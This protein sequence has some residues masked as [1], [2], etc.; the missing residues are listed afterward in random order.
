MAGARQKRRHV[1]KD[2]DIE[3]DTLEDFLKTSN[4]AA[5]ARIPGILVLVGLR[6]ESGLP[7]DDQEHRVSEF[8]EYHLELPG[9][10]RARGVDEL[11]FQAGLALRAQARRQE[12][13]TIACFPY[14]QLGDADK[15]KDRSSV[16]NFPAF[17][18]RA[19]KH[20]E[21]NSTSLIGA[22]YSQRRPRLRVRLWRMRQSSCAKKAPPLL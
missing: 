9:R 2:R 12:E 21:A 8:L 7:T 5:A 3:F 17:A 22:K 1:S 16:R 10:S 20:I 6:L 11:V 14:S 15:N 4:R 13:A 19:G 18:R